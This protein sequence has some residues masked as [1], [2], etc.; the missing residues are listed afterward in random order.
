MRHTDQRDFMISLARNA[1]STVAPEELPFFEAASEA[2]FRDPERALAADRGRDE[3]LG[4]GIDT[5]VA[6]VSPVAL[7]VAAAVYKQLTDQ[8]GAAV[9]RGGGRLVRR[10]FRRRGRQ[11]EP[12]AQLPAT[13]SEDDLKRVAQVV[14]E[15]ALALGLTGSRV[16][17][18]VDAVLASLTNDE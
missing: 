13:L 18:L 14:R 4:S 17:A 11:T 7:A 15:R 5:V 2:Y 6:L 1:V 16:D 12:A 9:V 8:V 10:I 3:I